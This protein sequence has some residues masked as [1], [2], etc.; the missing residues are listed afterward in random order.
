MPFHFS[1]VIWTDVDA[2]NPRIEKIDVINMRR[3]VIRRHVSSD[4]RS[5][6]LAIDFKD[7][8]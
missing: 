7:D 3:D 1:L 4:A 2:S 6:A 5:L 8:M